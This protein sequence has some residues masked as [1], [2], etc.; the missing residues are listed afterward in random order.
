MNLESILQENQNISKGEG[1][2]EQ[3][4]SYE[5]KQRKWR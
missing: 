3:I 1:V 5:R 4:E 2:T